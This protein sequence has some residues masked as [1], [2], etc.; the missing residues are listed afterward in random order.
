MNA[1]RTGAALETPGDAGEAAEHL[2]IALD[3]PT[4]DAALRQVDA[5]RGVCRW[6]KIGL[7]LF[8]AGGPPIVAAVQARGG[9]VFLDLKLHDIPETVARAVQAA[10]DLGV[11]LIT[12]HAAGGVEMVRRAAAGPVRVLAVTVLTS[13]DLADLA[14]LGVSAPSIEALVV[15]RAQLCLAAGAAGVVA[16]PRE[17]RALRAACG[18]DFLLVTPGVRAAAPDQA[19]AGRD[20]QKRIGLARQAIAE[21]ADLLVVG[22]PVRDAQDPVAAA[23]ALLRDIAAGRNERREQRQEQ[24]AA[25]DQETDPAT[26]MSS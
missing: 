3:H 20:D 6:Y 12:V 11:E 9:R 10:G 4:A 17:V 8:I 26:E 18:P 7:E 19:A 22:R 23:Q 13:L 15:R 5:L 24:A 2:A 21:G 25:P 14:P 16:S 1:R